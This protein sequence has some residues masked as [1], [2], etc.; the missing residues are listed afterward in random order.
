RVELYHLARR[1]AVQRGPDRAG[2]VPAAGREGPVDRR[3]HRDPADCVETRVPRGATV[4]WNDVGGDAFG[5]SQ[6]DDCDE[7]RQEGKTI[8]VQ[9]GPCVVQSKAVVCSPESGQRT[10]TGAPAHPKRA[11]A[12]VWWKP[13]RVPSVTRLLGSQNPVTRWTHSAL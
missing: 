1:A 10:V 5:V 2:V 3:A 8:P 13:V 9:H 7:D 11:P 12:Y 4:G 6:R